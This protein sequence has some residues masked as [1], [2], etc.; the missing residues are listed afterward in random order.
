MPYQQITK[1]QHGHCALHDSRQAALPEPYF[2]EAGLWVWLN[3]GRAVR[4]RRRRGG[5]FYKTEG[6][7]DWEEGG[8][9]FDK[10]NDGGD[11]EECKGGPQRN[12]GHYLGYVSKAL[13]DEVEGLGGAAHAAQDEDLLSDQPPLL[14]HLQRPLQPIPLAAHQEAHQLPRGV[15]SI[16][17]YLH[18]QVQI[19]AVRHCRAY[20]PEVLLACW[21]LSR[22]CILCLRR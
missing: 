17:L 6:G 9:G 19:A 18:R 3:G 16:Q 1:K 15:V 21:V 8:R 11:W 13:D 7:E 22:T 4:I 5:G 2:P 20:G 12:R 14:T 10:T